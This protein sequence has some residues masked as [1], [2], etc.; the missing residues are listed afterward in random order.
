MYSKILMT[1]AASALAMLFAS[2]AR[3]EMIT[4]KCP[5]GI[6]RAD[7]KTGTI[8]FSDGTV[9]KMQLNAA[10]LTWGLEWRAHGGAPKRINRKTGIIN[11]FEDW[12]SGTPTWGNDGDTSS[13]CHLV[14]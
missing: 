11:S 14:R 6:L 9:S 2:S 4:Y 13:P 12:G 3:A 1:A 10:Y 5:D 8:T 7:T